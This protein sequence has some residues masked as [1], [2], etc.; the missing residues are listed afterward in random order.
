MEDHGFRFSN[1]KLCWNSNAVVFLYLENAEIPGSSVNFD[2][3][4]SP[5][6]L[7]VQAQGRPA[8]SR[9]VPWSAVLGARSFFLVMV[10]D[11]IYAGYT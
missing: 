5:L 8:L 6:L 11:R 1:C 2:Q 7:T 9:S 4:N 10:P 3:S